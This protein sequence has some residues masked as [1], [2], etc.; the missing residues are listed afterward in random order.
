MS[1]VLF[2]LDFVDRG[3]FSVECILTLFAFKWLYP[4]SFFLSRGNHETDDM[5]KVYG[6]EGEVKHKFN[7]ATFKLFSEVFNWVPIAN[8]IGEKILVVHGGLPSQEGVTLDDIRKI[9]RNRQP[10]S[11][12]VMSDLLWAD[13]QPLPGRGPS[14]RGVGLQFGPDVTDAFLK[15][16][17]LELLVRSHEVKEA[18]YEIEHNRKCVTVFSAPNYWC[19]ASFRSEIFH[20]ATILIHCSPLILQRP[21]GEHG[22]RHFHHSKG[23]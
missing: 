23:K 20:L 13:P 9:D 14:K 22:I 6:F 18:G 19:V 15:R 4:N 1:F 10:G 3:S 17:N 16:N 5:N 12:G 11:D 8:V 7:D 2:S 21:N